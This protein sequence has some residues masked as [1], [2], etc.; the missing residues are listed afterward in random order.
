M[1]DCDHFV[2]RWPVLAD[3]F[4]APLHRRVLDREHAGG[5]PLQG[6]T[7]EVMPYLIYLS[8]V[9]GV[10]LD[11]PL[12]LARTFN[13]P[14]ARQARGGGL[15]IDLELFDRHVARLEQLGYVN[16]ARNLLW[17]LGRLLL[18]RGDPDLN[19]LGMDDLDGLRAATKEFAAALRLEP[20]REFY[21]RSHNG[22]RQPDPAKSSVATALARLHEVHVLLFHIGQVQTP[23]RARIDAGTWTDRLAPQAAPP[24]IRAV[25]ERYLR[26]HLD[27]SL[28]RP[29]TVRH[30][31]DALHRLVAWMSQAHPQMT[32]L[33]QLHR[34]HA[35]EF[36]TWMGTQV[37]R[38]TGAPLT[39]GHRRTVITLITRFITETAAWGWDDVPDRV[40]FTR[41]D[42]PKISRG[43]PRF[44]PD[45]ELAALMAAVDQLTNPHQRAALIVARWSGA[46]RDEIRRLAID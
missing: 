36:L 20:V 40:L 39:V 17:P 19:A 2:A 1:N 26:L 45:H 13:S 46:R 18:H 23:P 44:I 27:A 21:S 8:L 10:G 37:S 11:Y 29:Q 34:E 7:S 12:L 24:R 9:H 35:E 6:G 41:A 31:R 4:A 38:H 16:S 15:G 33:A 5:S 3:W 43:L 25:V 30:S 14:F 32:S 22:R 28:D 42:I